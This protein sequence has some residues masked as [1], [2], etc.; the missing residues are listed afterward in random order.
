[1]KINTKIIPKGTQAR[2]GI[3]MTPKYIT[4]HETDNTSKGAWAKNHA[5]LQ[6]NGNDRQASW[7]YTVD[8]HE[9]WQSIP[10]K[11]V[12]WHAGDGRGPGNMSSIAIEICVNSDG[13][14]TKAKRLAAELAAELLNKYSLP[15]SRL[16]QHNHWSGK[17]CPRNLRKSGWSA[18]KKDVQS[19]MKGKK[20][21]APPK[22]NPKW[23]G[24]SFP[25]RSAFKIGKKH[26]AVT[27]LGK[28]LVAHGFDKH[29]KE[30]PGPTFTEADRKNCQD[31]QKAQGWK[32]TDTDGYPGPSTW[33]RL[34]KE[35]Q[36]KEP[37]PKPSKDLHRV[38][39]DGKQVGAYGEAQ[40]VVAAVEKGLKKNPN[41]IQVEKVKK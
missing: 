40:N 31:F 12:A 38:K 28:R 1:M 34:M 2:P 7:H 21:S 10:E 9:I 26:D 41:K 3:A 23:D 24:K 5:V 6:Y 29:Y 25:G 35:P 37:K 33:E 36:K 16:V 4:I 30:G 27:M 15:I 39:V 22:P 8:D 18:F 11:E 32:G 14:F 17:N 20:P 13:D 19:F